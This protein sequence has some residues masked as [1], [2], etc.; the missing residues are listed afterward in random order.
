MRPAFRRLIEMVT[1]R[2]MEITKAYFMVPVQDMDR[3]LS[4]YRDVLGLEQGVRS[5]EWSELRWRD[6]TI[7]LHG[8]GLEDG[9]QSWL[10]FYVDD[11]D[12]AAQ[13]IVT[14]G[15]ARGEERS[16]GGIRLLA[17]TDTEGNSLTLG[18]QPSWG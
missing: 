14:A 6:A 17:V 2:E 5:P 11:L 9:R 13:E 18:Q 7:A 3:A 8:G 16:E 1:V 4:F 15:G 10:G 12:A